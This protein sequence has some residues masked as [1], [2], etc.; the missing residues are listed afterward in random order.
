MELRSFILRWFIEKQREKPESSVEK[1]VELRLGC[2]F[3]FSWI[4]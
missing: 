1:R 2:K 4:R 3:L